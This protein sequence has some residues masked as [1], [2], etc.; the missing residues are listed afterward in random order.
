MVNFMGALEVQ[1]LIK[2]VKFIAFLRTPNRYYYYNTVIQF[3]FVNTLN[4]QRI[5]KRFIIKFK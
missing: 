1:V 5:D 4:T 3:I 2:L